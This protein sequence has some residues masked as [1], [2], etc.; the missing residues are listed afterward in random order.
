MQLLQ[1]KFGHVIFKIS[2]GALG[3]GLLKQ[4]LRSVSLL[5]SEQ[6]FRCVK[7]GLTTLPRQDLRVALQSDCVD[8]VQCQFVE[9]EVNKRHRPLSGIQ[10]RCIARNLRSIRCTGTSEH[11]LEPKHGVDIFWFEFDCLLQILCGI[12]KI[13]RFP[14][15]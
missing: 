15:K 4:R 12:W 11:H 2:R 9:I 8:V 14:V 5:S 6:P 7:I 10:A 13:A 3:N 1:F